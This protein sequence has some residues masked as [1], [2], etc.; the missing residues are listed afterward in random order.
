MA[1]SGID[2]FYRRCDVLAIVFGDES[3]DNHSV[4]L[5]RKNKHVDSIN[6]VWAD[7][8]RGCRHKSPTN[9]KT[10]KSSHPLGIIKKATRHPTRFFPATKLSGQYTNSIRETYNDELTINFFSFYLKAVAWRPERAHFQST[11]IYH[12]ITLSH[13]KYM[14][15]R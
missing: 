10:N 4:R 1:H 6:R 3:L 13:A 2:G 9:N 7:D 15:S 11:Q 12:V 14:H 5:M 8:L